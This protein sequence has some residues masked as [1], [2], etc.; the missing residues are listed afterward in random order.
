M[1]MHG[2]Q[3]DGRDAETQ[4]VLERRLG[5]EAQIGAAE[6]R[7]DVLVERREALD[8]Q[9]VDDRLVPRVPRAPVVAPGER[10]I[11][12]RGERRVLRAVGLV[13]RPVAIG[14]LREREQR[15]IPPQRTADALRVRIEQDLG[16]VEPVAAL[17]R[18]RSVHAV[19]V[20]LTGPD[21]GKITVPDHVR[22][23]RQRDADVLHDGARRIEEAQVD[24]GGVLG[25]EREVDAAG[26]PGRAE[27]I[28]D[29]G[30]HSHGSSVS[31][32]LAPPATAAG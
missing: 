6:P 3:L 10:G 13:R 32:W 15:A 11:D 2:H 29:S 1:V 20:D 8:V 14:A 31:T 7:R 28:R 4:E 18:P 23:L 25:E 5:R 9:L 24:A 17:G 30:P 16:A 26:V 19:P 22:P 21:V 12:H 27:R